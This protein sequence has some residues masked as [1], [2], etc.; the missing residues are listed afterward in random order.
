MNCSAVLIY[1]SSFRTQ[2]LSRILLVQS[3]LVS[4]GGG[5]FL[6]LDQPALL[7][8]SSL[9]GGSLA[10]DFDFLVLVGAQLVGEVG[11]FGRLRSL[12]DG[13][14]LDVSV[15]VTGLGG[16]G[17]VSL[18]LAEVELLDGVRCKDCQWD[19]CSCHPCDRLLGIRGDGAGTITGKIHP[20]YSFKIAIC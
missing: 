9:T 15:G 14:L 16:S 8:R 5:L 17:L 18:N 1:K 7:S 2:L 20:S 4:S 19:F 12:G 6:L 10:L 3:P 13:E 11:L